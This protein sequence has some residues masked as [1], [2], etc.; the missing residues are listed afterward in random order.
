MDGGSSTATTREGTT[1]TAFVVA[2][3]TRQRGKHD[4]SWLSR[5]EIG[6]QSPAATLQLAGRSAAATHPPLPCLLSLQG[7]PPACQPQVN[8]LAPPSPDLGPD[9]G[10]AGPAMAPPTLLRR[11]RPRRRSSSHPTRRFHAATPDRR[12]PKSTAASPRSPR[13]PTSQ[14]VESTPPPAPHGQRPA[15]HADGGGK[16]GRGRK[17]E[18]ELGKRRGAAAAESPF[19][20][21]EST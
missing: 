8:R 5:A 18:G 2:D 11:Q 13:P 21:A 19:V 20:A 12:L 9:L 6:P 16:G 4:P 14:R 10:R 7:A 1:S 17:P 15:A 3:W